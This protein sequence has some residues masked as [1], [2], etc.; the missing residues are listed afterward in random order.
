MCACACVYVC[1]RRDQWKTSIAC[2]SGG[3]FKTI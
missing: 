3:S 2:G 1:V